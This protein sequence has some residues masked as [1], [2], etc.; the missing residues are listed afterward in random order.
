MSMTYYDKI[1]S[2]VKL[3]NL[4]R[5]DDED[6]DT[7]MYFIHESSKLK[8]R[9]LKCVDDEAIT[10]PQFEIESSWKNRNNKATKNRPQMNSYKYFYFL[11][12]HQNGELV[13]NLDEIMNTQYE[14]QPYTVF[15][16]EEM[17][18]D[19]ITYK[20]K[21]NSLTTDIQL[22][23][24]IFID[25]Y[26]N[27]YNYPELMVKDSESIFVIKTNDLITESSIQLPQDYF[28]TGES[29]NPYKYTAHF[30]KIPLFDET[31]L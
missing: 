18:F 5:I 20:M 27:K 31:C 9:I 29:D 10:Y 22:A 26:A 6:D 24:Q 25:Y 28:F 7:F 8:Y 21:H 16:M 14:G 3:C 15:E 4:T 1:N 13:K 2:F 17:L 11:T 30:E 23:D 12:I 19:H